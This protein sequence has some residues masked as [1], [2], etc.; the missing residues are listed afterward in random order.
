MFSIIM[1]KTSDISKTDLKYFC[2]SCVLEVIKKVF[3]G[4]FETKR[5]NA[6]SW[7][8]LAKDAMQSLNLDLNN[9]F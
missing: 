1:D 8:N 7:F 3:V 4:F 2:L 5:T 6:D 9:I